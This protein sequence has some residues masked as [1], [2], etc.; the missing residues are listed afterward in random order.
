MNHSQDGRGPAA[1]VISGSH[2]QDE[3]NIGCNGR[4]RVKNG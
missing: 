1:E 4:I 3:K 2:F